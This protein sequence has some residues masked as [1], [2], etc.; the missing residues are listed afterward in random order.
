MA[1][2]RQPIMSLRRQV[3]IYWSY[4]FSGLVSLHIFM[5]PILYILQFYKTESTILIDLWEFLPQI[6]FYTLGLSRRYLLLSLFVFSFLLL[7]SLYF[8]KFTSIYGLFLL[9][10]LIWKIG[11]INRK[12][13]ISYDGAPHS[14]KLIFFINP[15]RKWH[16]ILRGA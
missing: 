1:F 4:C 15:L 3:W 6:S 11:F 2:W 13:Y 9:G 16:Q 7:V 12:I 8:Y 14:T 5:S 10:L